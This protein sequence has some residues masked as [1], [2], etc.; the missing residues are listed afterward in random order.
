[1]K[2]QTKVSNKA[3]STTGNRYDNE[4]RKS[5]LAFAKTHTN[6]ETAEKF[7]CATGLVLFLRRFGLKKQS[8]ITA[9]E[10][11]AALSKPVVKKA[12]APVKV[13]KSML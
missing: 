9:A 6:A 4:A 11:K 7:G 13:K 8:E 10:R 2:S 1:M 5:I 3:K 12:A